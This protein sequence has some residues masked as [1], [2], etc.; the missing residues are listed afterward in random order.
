MGGVSDNDGIRII[1]LAESLG[2]AFY[3]FVF[4]YVGMIF[5]KKFSETK[6]YFDSHRKFTERQEINPGA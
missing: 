6:V 3:F 5:F 4:Q 2:Q 1:R